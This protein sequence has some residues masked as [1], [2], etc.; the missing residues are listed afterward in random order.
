MYWIC[1]SFISSR[2]F[3]VGTKIMT[4]H[5]GIKRAKL[6]ETT[7]EGEREPRDLILRSGLSAASRRMKALWLYG[8]RRAPDS[9]ALP[10]RRAPHHE[11]FGL[12]RIP[13]ENIRRAVEL[14]ERRLQRRH[15]VLG[16][17]LRR[18]AFGAMNRAQWS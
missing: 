8:S 11:V 4:S 7:R 1:H 13:V 10:G 16:E 9:A 12:D 5:S 3:F 15:A 18:P 14:V 17:R 2:C 6:C